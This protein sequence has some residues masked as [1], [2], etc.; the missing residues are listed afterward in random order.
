MWKMIFSYRWNRKNSWKFC[1]RTQL[2]EA[3]N[4]DAYI[5]T[6]NF[7]VIQAIVMPH[8]LSQSH[9]NLAWTAA[10]DYITWHDTNK[11]MS[12][13]TADFVFLYNIYDI[14]KVINLW[15]TAI[16]FV[17][18]FYTIANWHLRCQ[19]DLYGLP[20][21]LQHESLICCISRFYIWWRCL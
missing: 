13:N 19:V 1:K 18:N 17:D 5:I 6:V 11:L 2:V 9:V 15:A 16:F 14:L 4:I 21:D 8:S 7:T 3:E 10:K 12:K 20:S